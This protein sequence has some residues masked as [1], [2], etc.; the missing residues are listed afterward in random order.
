MLANA[1]AR[2]VRR[3]V[4]SASTQQRSTDR[5][6]DSDDA[7]G[8]HDDNGSDADD[9][10]D[11]RVAALSA[12]PAAPRVTTT[13]ESLAAASAPELRRHGHARRRR[14]KKH[15]QAAD[16]ARPAAPILSDRATPQDA[17]ASPA[18]TPLAQPQ[19]HAGADEPEQPHDA[20]RRRRKIRSRQKNI[21]KD[22]R[23]P[24]LR[25]TYWTPGAPDYAGRG[26]PSTHDAQPLAH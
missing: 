22:H 3:G 12:L 7:A 16:N 18:P 1:V 4:P 25:P 8:A 21:R 5:G 13:L 23:P 9:A 6:D 10:G 2:A 15:A 11:S 26:R 24:E 20:P 19:R 17:E 14:H